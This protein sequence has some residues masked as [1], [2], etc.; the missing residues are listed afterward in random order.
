MNDMI[1]WRAKKEEIARSGLENYRLWLNHKMNGSFVNYQALYQWS[2]EQYEQFWESMLEYFDIQYSGSYAC[3][4]NRLSMPKTKWFEGIQLNYAEHIFRKKSEEYP[5]FL[6]CTE[7]GQIRQINWSEL[8]N[9]VSAIQKFLFSKNIQVGDRVAAFVPNVVESSMVMLAAIASGMVWSSCSPDFGVTSAQER[10]RQIEPRVFIACTGYSYGGKVFDRR[11]EVLAILSTLEHVEVVI[12]LESYDLEAPDG[13]RFYKFQEIK[14]INDPISFVRL[15]FDHPIWILYSSGTTGMP[16][17]IVHGHGGMLLEHLKY[18]KLHNDV[19]PGERFFWYS[20]TGWMMW[21]FVHGSLLVGATAV[22]YD[23]SPAFPELSFLWAFAERA[24]INHF[25]TSAPYL[26]SCMK[27]GLKP[28]VQ[29]NLSYIRSI[30]STG[31]PLPPEAFDWVYHA[32]HQN[33][34]LCSMSGGTDVCT[35]FVGSCIEW[36]VYRGEIQCRALGVS[37]EAWDEYGHPV[38]GT[39]GEMVLTRP[40]PCM[41]I[42]FWNDPDY[43]KYTSSYFEMYPGVWRHGDWIEVTSH[44]GVIISGRSDATLNRQGVRIGTAEIYNV[45]NEIPE[46]KESLIVNLEHPNGDH[47]MPLFIQLKDSSTDL[48]LLFLNIRNKLKVQCSPRHVPDQI[49]VVPDIPFTISGKKME[50]PVKKVLMKMDLTRAYNPDA[51]RNPDSM[52]FF[53][54]NAER[55]GVQSK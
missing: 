21:N 31:S 41:P 44:G 38:L 28:G 16:K 37:M 53:I 55:W 6:A 22:L 26:V 50:G 8:E 24:Q 43:E 35:A 36:P 42:K 49:T 5:A 10:F 46:I 25:G 1:L 17:A 23:G 9:H 52:N 13:E 47:F 19:K 32:I 11:K 30:G 51:M 54:E 45:L 7:E 14:P 34:W 48:Q 40:M 39:V 18:L 27:E 2:I 15:P 12:W 29:F 20:T 3:V 4:S 33:V